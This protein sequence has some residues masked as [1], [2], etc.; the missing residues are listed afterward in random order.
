MVITTLVLTCVSALW[1]ASVEARKYEDTFSGWSFGSDEADT[2]MIEGGGFINSFTHNSTLGQ[3]T[4]GGAGDLGE[5]DGI[6]FCDFDPETGAPRGI[7]LDYLTNASVLRAPNGDL[8]YR[9]LSN[10]PPSTL[11][12]NFVDNQSFTFEVYVDFVG[13]TGKYEGA[14]GTALIRGSGAFVSNVLIA[15][16]GTSEGEILL[17]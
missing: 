13:G 10:S 12:F 2:D 4:S 16:S 17:D 11:C 6:T 1:T 8:L 9:R 15:I 7:V 14:T 3:L 5:F